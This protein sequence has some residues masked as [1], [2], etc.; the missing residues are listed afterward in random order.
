MS[1]STQLH[2]CHHYCMEIFIAGICS[3]FFLMQLAMWSPQIWKIQYWLFQDAWDPQN[4]QWLQKPALAWLH[5]PL[6]V[7]C[8]PC[9]LLPS[10]LTADFVTFFF[11]A[12]STAQPSPH[13]EGNV[14][15]S[16]V[17]ANAVFCQKWNN[18]T[19]V[20]VGVWLISC[21]GHSWVLGGYL[22]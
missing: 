13:A 18:S 3:G 10:T 14:L 15:T 19:F 4:T 12:L 17:R 16:H 9:C 11:P 1:G 20:A 21:Y 7:F 6:G 5:S 22:L 2:I 8:W